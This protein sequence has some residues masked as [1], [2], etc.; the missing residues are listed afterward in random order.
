M[1]DCSQQFTR[2]LQRNT[3]SRI[4]ADGLILTE[5]ENSFV[6]DLQLFLIADR[7][8]EAFHICTKYAP[9]CRSSSGN[10]SV[11]L[12][13]ESDRRNSNSNQIAIGQLMDRRTLL[14]HDS[15]SFGLS[16]SDRINHN[17]VA[18]N[19][20]NRS[21]ANLADIH[22]NRTED[23]A[24]DFYNELDML[25]G[26][27][28]YDSLDLNEDELMADT[29]NR[30]AKVNS[31][32]TTGKLNLHK[33]YMFHKKATHTVEGRGRNGKKTKTTKTT[34]SI[35]M[36]TAAQLDKSR[37]ARNETEY[38]QT[39][40]FDDMVETDTMAYNPLR[41]YPGPRGY[42]G[43]IGSIGDPGQKGEPGRDGLSGTIGVQGPPGHVFM[44][45]VRAQC[46]NNQIE[47]SKGKQIF[48]VDQSKHWE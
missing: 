10:G 44:I 32:K 11:S 37:T 28:Y 14:N 46:Y 23:F 1:L 41:G 22:V 42:P 45:P 36:T 19:S 24:F 48:N 20:R 40:H 4:A 6:G 25:N 17:S 7:P 9:D 21:N 3:R 38:M 5:E 13:I 30:S 39:E 47:Q 16:V 12:S 18:S 2:K 15:S 27:D 33:K 26:S 31:T 29:N 8:D 43:A 35:E 34:T